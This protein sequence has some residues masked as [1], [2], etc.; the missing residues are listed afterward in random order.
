VPGEKWESVSVKDADSKLALQK[1]YLSKVSTNEKAKYLRSKHAIKSS[2]KWR[3]CGSIQG[4]SEVDFWGPEMS[5][6][7]Q[8]DDVSD[9]EDDTK[10]CSG[11]SMSCVRHGVWN[12]TSSHAQLSNNTLRTLYFIGIGS[13]LINASAHHDNDTVQ[14]VLLGIGEATMR[15]LT[16]I[17][18]GS[19][20]DGKKIENSRFFITTKERNTLRSASAMIHGF[21]DHNGFECPICIIP[22]NNR[23]RPVDLVEFQAEQERRMIDNQTAARTKSPK[24]YQEFRSMRSVLGTVENKKVGQ[25]WVGEHK[26]AVRR[27]NIMP[28]DSEWKRVSNKCEVLAPLQFQG[29]AS[30]RIDILFQRL[31][32]HGRSVLCTLY[33]EKAVRLFCASIYAS[34]DKRRNGYGYLDTYPE[35]LVAHQFHGPELSDLLKNACYELVSL[36]KPERGDNADVIDEK[37][38]LRNHIHAVIGKFYGYHGIPKWIF[39]GWCDLFEDLADDVILKTFIKCPNDEHFV[40]LLSQSRQIAHGQPPPYSSLATFARAYVP[41]VIRSFAQ[42]PLNVDAENLID[43]AIQREQLDWDDNEGHLSYSDP[44]IA[45][46]QYSEKIST[47]TQPLTLEHKQSNALFRLLKIPLS[48]FL[49]QEVL[50]A[51]YA[52]T[53]K[54]RGY[55]QNALLTN[56]RKSS[57][58]KGSADFL[59]QIISEWSRVEASHDAE[60]GR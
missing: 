51:C 12:T 28:E 2:K 49:T 58:R 21:G 43:A 9:F 32:G 46:K 11:E 41:C 45:T 31:S 33:D 7:L 5:K 13:H 19:T 20:V 53:G 54:K 57:S 1:E 23:S 27:L 16:F 42:L 6:S 26:H 60:G 18:H 34:V 22:Q 25:K 55:S 29:S 17:R 59:L 56:Y 36:F 44:R 52:H 39:R 10:P 8:I 35:D 3:A 4:Y 40:K 15:E 24:M 38:K 48:S 30:G 50:E 14:S 37:K 47:L